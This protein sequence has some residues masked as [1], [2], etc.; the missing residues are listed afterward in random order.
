MLVGLGVR[1][2]LG[3]GVRLGEGGWVEVEAKV[4]VEIAAAVGT[5]LVGAWTQPAAAMERSTISPARFKRP[6]PGC[7]SRGGSNP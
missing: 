5:G 3:S 2:G 6:C 7:Q 4:F 1:V